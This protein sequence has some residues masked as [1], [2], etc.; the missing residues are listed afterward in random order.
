MKWVEIISSFDFLKICDTMNVI[1]HRMYVPLLIL[2]RMVWESSICSDR[3]LLFFKKIWTC[4]TLCTCCT[5]HT[6]TLRSYTGTLWTEPRFS[7]HKYFFYSSCLSSHCKPCHLVNTAYEQCSTE[8]TSYNH[9]PP[10]SL[11]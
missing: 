7:K 2:W 10:A 6:S 8:H 5:H 11:I 9:W 3:N 4:D 1:Y